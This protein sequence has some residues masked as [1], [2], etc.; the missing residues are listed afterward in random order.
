MNDTLDIA[1][2]TGGHPY[3]VRAFDTF[4]KAMPGINAVVQ[5]IDDFTASPEEVRDSYA[6]V[7]FFFMPA[8]DPEEDDAPWFAGNPKAAL[9]HLGATNQGI[10]VLHHAIL[11]YRS[12]PGWADLCALPDRDGFGFAPDERVTVTM[13]NREHPITFGIDDWRLTDEVYTI[14]SSL[15]AGECDLLMTTDHPKSM[16]ALG[17]TRMHGSSRVFCFQPGHDSTAWS[18]PIFAEVL[19][20]G[21]RWAA[22][23]L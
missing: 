23:A 18:N 2:V 19:R 17:W 14:N 12:W 10:V 13:V 22:R 1:V 20:R 9:E 5:N 8:G 11:A 7:V 4:W 6:A 15:P 3:E 16:E 21:V